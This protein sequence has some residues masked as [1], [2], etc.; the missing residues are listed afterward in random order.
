MRSSYCI[1]LAKD[2]SSVSLHPKVLRLGNERFSFRYRLVLCMCVCVCVVCIRG[3]E[4]RHF[5][6]FV[7][8]EY[9]RPRGVESNVVLFEWWVRPETK[10][11]ATADT[12]TRSLT[13]LLVRMM[14]DPHHVTD[15]LTRLCIIN[16]PWTLLCTR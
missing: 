15:S 7:E 16:R 10:R 2:A 5:I 3:S 9:I 14:D 12:C 6:S 8:L 11:R 4:R 1:D 13:C